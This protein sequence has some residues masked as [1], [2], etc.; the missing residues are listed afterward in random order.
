MSALNTSAGMLSGV[1]TV[2]DF[3]AVSGSVGNRNLKDAETN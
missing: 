1:L 2:Q 3:H